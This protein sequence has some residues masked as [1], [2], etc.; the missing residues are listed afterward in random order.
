M[1]TKNARNLLNLIKQS[2]DNIIIKP[3][4]FIKG[5]DANMANYIK[6]MISSDCIQTLPITYYVKPDTNLYEII[7]TNNILN[8]RMHT[9][10]IKKETELINESIYVNSELVVFNTSFY[11]YGAYQLS[12]SL[13]FE[14]REYLDLEL[15][16]NSYH[17]FVKS[18]D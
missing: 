7:I 9:V 5:V 13:Y 10:V 1:S 17:N 12:H 15:D 4:S 16:I 2:R 6:F 18:H 11:Y 8:R 3:E 14:F